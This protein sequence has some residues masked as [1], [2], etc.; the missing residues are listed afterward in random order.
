MPG[1]CYQCLVLMHRAGMLVDILFLLCQ[2]DVLLMVVSLCSSM[3]APALASLTTKEYSCLVPVA[4]IFLGWAGDCFDARIQECLLRECQ[5]VDDGAKEQCCSLYPVQVLG[6]R[7]GDEQ[8]TE[9]VA[10]CACQGV[11]QA[12]ITGNITNITLSGQYTRPSCVYGHK[13]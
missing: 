9:S 5:C 4:R 11:G 6:M 1:L 12:M 7:Q 13:K 2:R 3:D 8:S 10:V